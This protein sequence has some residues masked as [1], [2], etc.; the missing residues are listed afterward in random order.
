MLEKFIVFVIKSIL[1]GIVLYAILIIV[2][3]CLLLPSLLYGNW[4]YT[5]N[6]STEDKVKYA[7]MAS[8]PEI[9]D[10]IECYGTMGFW[11]KEYSVKTSSFSSLDELC[12]IMPAN[13]QKAIRTTMDEKIGVNGETPFMCRISEDDFPPEIRE[14]NDDYERR[15]L[16]YTNE[17]GECYLEIY[18]P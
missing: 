3:A 6:L 7:Q 9:A 8:L 15:Y 11:H 17:N 2:G 5:K 16:I 13:M 4:K 18:F 10:S 1:I 14:A 12:A